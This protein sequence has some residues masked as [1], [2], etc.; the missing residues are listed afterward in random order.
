MSVLQGAKMALL[1]G[2]EL[3]PAETKLDCMLGLEGKA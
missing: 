3:L 2:V 1:T